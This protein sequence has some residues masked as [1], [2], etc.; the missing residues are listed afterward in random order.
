MIDNM[1]VSF[2]E[3]RWQRHGADTITAILARAARI[4]PERIFIDYGGR[5]RTFHEFE[6][7][8]TLLANGLRSFGVKKGDTVCALLDTSI[9]GALFWFAVNKTGAIYVPMNT[10]LKGDFLAHQLTDADSGIIIAHSTY[11][12]RILE[13][14]DQL[15]ADLTIF[16]DAEIPGDGSTHIH[17]IDELRLQSGEPADV[18]FNP[19]DLSVILYT[20]GTTGLPKGCMASHEYVCNVAKRVAQTMAMTA[21]DVSWSPLPLFHIFGSCGVVL[22]SLHC[23]ARV[24][25]NRRFSVSNF[26]P[27]VER[28]GAT[29]LNLVGSMIP[30]VGGAPA[31]EAERRCFGQ[32]RIAFG[33]PFP[34]DAIAHWRSRFGIQWAGGG[35]YGLTEA[36]RISE[37]SVADDA[38][39]ATCGRPLSF[40]VRIFGADDEEC[41]PGK[42]GEIVVRPLRPGVMFDGYW[43]R[44]DETLQAMRGLWFHTGDIGKFDQN[45]NLVFVDRK[46]DYIRCGGENVSSYEIETALR[47]HPAILDIAAYA[48]PSALAEDEIKISVILKP[49]SAI[50]ERELCLWA[51]ERLPYFCVPHYIEIHQD[52]PRSP[53]GKV[54]KYLLKEAGVTTRSWV[55]ARSGISLLRK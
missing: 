5:T 12:P 15:R 39:S 43:R 32:V 20:S 48:V 18:A 14:R 52:L 7:E 23:G 11:V 55:R 31:S 51:I 35:G 27:E 8:S 34:A 33:I 37:L 50:T 40:E 1:A 2:E 47:R 46:K 19:G 4:W 29:I 42:P 13:I 25:L 16:S 9:E 53:T 6:A 3:N 41:P 36:A 17:H 30:L 49:D 45:G 22:A 24:A 54:L 38:A 10:A 44:Q 28:T 21:D 26:W